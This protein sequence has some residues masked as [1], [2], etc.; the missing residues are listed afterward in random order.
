MRP[1]RDVHESE[2]PLHTRSVDGVVTFG[3]VT[4]VLPQTFGRRKSRE[5]CTEVEQ[6]LI[7]ISRDRDLSLRDLNSW[8][9]PIYLSP[10]CTPTVPLI[11]SVIYV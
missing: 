3:L 4:F 7:L 8:K 2:S 9:D 10:F 11:Y 5:G 1:L 6:P